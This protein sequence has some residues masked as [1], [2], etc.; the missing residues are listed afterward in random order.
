LSVSNADSSCSTASS[1]DVSTAITVIL[2]INLTQELAENAFQVFIKQCKR[3]DLNS[4][5]KQSPQT[6]VEDVADA[7]HD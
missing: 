7:A 4:N 3:N 2:G 5:R 6:Q 1:D